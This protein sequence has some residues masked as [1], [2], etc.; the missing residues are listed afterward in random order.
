M[1][2]LNLLLLFSLMMFFQ[3]SFLEA[4]SAPEKQS[5]PMCLGC[6]SNL[7]GK[8]FIHLQ[9]HQK[10]VHGHLSCLSCHSPDRVAS[11]DPV[12][13]QSVPSNAAL[14]AYPEPLSRKSRFPDA[15]TACGR[16]HER[17]FGQVRQSVH[18]RAVFEKGNPDAAFCSDCHTPI[19]YIKAV[20]DVSS[21]VA[22]SNLIHTCSQCHANRVI[23]SRYHL[24]VS[25]VQSYKAHFHG[26]KYSLGSKETPTCAVCHGHHTIR[27]VK[28]PESP[29]SPENKV[30][31]CARCH[32][33]ATPAFSELFTHTPLNAG[34]NPM[35]LRVRKVL[36]AFLV[37]FVCVLSLH[38]LLDI[39]K[40]IRS[41]GRKARTSHTRNEIPWTLFQRLPKK[42]ERMDLHL[43]IQHALLFIAVFYLAASGIALKFP[44]MHFSETWI[45]LWGGVENAGRLH[46]FSALILMIDL[47]YHLLYLGIQG[48]RKK[49]CLSMIPRIEDF[50]HLCQ[51]LR[52]LSGRG[53]DR[54]RFGTFTYIQKL[55][56]WVVMIVVLIMI[57]TGLMYW[58]PVI[59]V[60]IFPDPVF[61]WIW[62]AAYV[63][64]STEAILILFFAFVWHFYHVHLKSRVFPMSWI[65]IT[66][67]IDLEDLMEEHPGNFEEI[68][69][70]ERKK[71]EPDTKGESGSE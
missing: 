63:I 19:H 11:I 49:L 50:R 7:T 28:D 45:G 42:V 6:H 70:A 52:Y 30:S 10:S 68:L 29:V 51:N 2:R 44:E 60:R 43:R 53:G 17:I 3:A 48:F 24:N 59:A 13:R 40:E 23:A 12:H 39:A 22:R 46:R 56:Y 16:C 69:D 35:A 67:K 37:I 58:F 34:S 26:K 54:P 4:V 25:V 71:G 38:L 64:H 31:L 65:W 27:D 5:P 20:S 57:I 9:R 32:E 18:G 62:G 41:L 1:K 21:S 47:L 55:D 33:G 8:N 14:A 15:L 61:K 66:G 36:V